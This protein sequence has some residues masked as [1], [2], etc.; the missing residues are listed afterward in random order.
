M[1]THLFFLLQSRLAGWFKDGDGPVYVDERDGR[2]RTKLLT[3]CVRLRRNDI[4]MF[5]G[6][7]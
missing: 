7:S 4:A 2:Y 6:D 1:H 5:V 3:E